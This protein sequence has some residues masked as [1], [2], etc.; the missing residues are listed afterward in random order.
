VNGNQMIGPPADA[1]VSVA[2]FSEVKPGPEI[3][4]IREHVKPGMTVVDLGANIGLYTLQFASLVGPSG[5]VFAFEPG[6]LSF[7]LLKTNLALN[8]YRNVTVENA[9]VSDFSGETELHICSTGE[10]DNRIA[11]FETYESER[12]PVR[13]FALDDYFKPGTRVDFIKIDIQGAEAKALQGMRRMLI[14][15]PLIQLFVEANEGV[16]ETADLLRLKCVP[17]GPADFILQR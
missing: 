1:A 4:F 5:R 11:G 16:R 15:N 12:V 8:G 7:G 14:D 13:C 2:G 10:S 9:A 17:V 3:D 6:P